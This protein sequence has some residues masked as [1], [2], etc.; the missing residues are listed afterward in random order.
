MGPKQ[1]LPVRITRLPQDDG[2]SPAAWQASERV[3]VGHSFRQSQT[4][5]ESLVCAGVLPEPGSSD[6]RAK[7]GAM[8]KDDAVVA[9]ILHRFPERFAH[10]RAH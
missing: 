2:L 7:H 5:G 4:V 10:S 1:F 9:G 8:D 3:L 6:G